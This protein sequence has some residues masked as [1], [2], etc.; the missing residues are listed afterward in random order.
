MRGAA[1][2]VYEQAGGERTFT[3]IV[4]R[5][6]S[7]VANDPVL[8]P[9]YGADE[10]HLWRAAEHLRL[11]LIQYWGGPTWYSDQRGHPRLRMRHA[12]FSIG[13]A[14]RE[15]WLRHMTAAV[16]SVDL[17]P[18]IRDAFVEYFES[19]ALAMM[20]RADPFAGRP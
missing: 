13:H 9:L 6:Y 3:L 17:Q 5:F 15:A 20:N 1:A 4:E 8:R 19:A 16:G 11:F 14:E 18:Q 10:E 7:E 12:P 2:T